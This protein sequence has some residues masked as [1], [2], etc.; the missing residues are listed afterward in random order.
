MPSSLIIADLHLTSGEV[1]KTNLFVKFCQEQATK[2][3]QLFI[4]GDLFNTWLG[5][6]L[7][8]E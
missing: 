1:D 5:D 6:D 7:S 3:D 2:V 4:L 8:L